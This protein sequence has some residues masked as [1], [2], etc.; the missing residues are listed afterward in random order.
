[1]RVCASTVSDANC[2]DV[3]T[4]ERTGR[5]WSTSWSFQENTDFRQRYSING[6][7]YAVVSG[8][9]AGRV[10]QPSNVRDARRSRR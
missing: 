9:A 3:D 8:G 10:G 2:L 1:M 5:L 4:N 7:L 6:S